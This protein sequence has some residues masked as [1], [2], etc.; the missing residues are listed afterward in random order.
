MSKQDVVKAVKKSI[1]EM[2][3]NQIKLLDGYYKV[4]DYFVQSWKVDGD[5]FK[6]KDA[7]D[8]LDFGASVAYGDFGIVYFLF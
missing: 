3:D 8:A 6:M 5:N 4:N 2:E 7:H 1:K